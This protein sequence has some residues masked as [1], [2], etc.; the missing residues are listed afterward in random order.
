M[1]LASLSKVNWPYMFVFISRISVL[2]HW[3]ICLSL[4]Q[5]DTFDYYSFLISFEIR[6]CEYSNF[7]FLFK[8]MFDY[9][10][11]LAVVYEFEDWHK[12]GNG[13]LDLT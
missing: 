7:A 3:S 11:S 9:L 12:F 6:K 8:I 13:F 1:V 4:C 5:Y 10:G 2:F